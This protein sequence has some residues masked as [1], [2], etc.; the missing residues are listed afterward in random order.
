MIRTATGNSTFWSRPTRRITDS[1]LR[2]GTAYRYRIRARDGRNSVLS[3]ETVFTYP[4]SGVQ[5]RKGAA[6]TTEP[7][8]R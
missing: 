7:T 1:G 8:P 3:R 5:Q 4:Q 2:P 6:P